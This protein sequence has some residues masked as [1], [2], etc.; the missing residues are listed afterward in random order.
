MAYDLET[1]ERVRR[2]L[3]TERGIEEKRMVGGLSFSVDGKMCCGVAGDALMV[4]VGGE[5]RERTL[6]PNRMCGRWCLASGR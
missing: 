5:A 1:V 4:R 3:S 6:A 2:V